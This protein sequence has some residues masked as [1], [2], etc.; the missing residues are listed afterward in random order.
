[1]KITKFSIKKIAI[2]FLIL[3]IFYIN[4][5]A[6]DTIAEDAIVLDPMPEISASSYMLLDQNTGHILMEHNID[7]MI[8]PASV[9]KIL[10]A[11]LVIENCDPDE[12]VTITKDAFWNI[13]Y[14]SSSAGLVEGEIMS[15]NDMLYCMML[16]SANEAS[17][18]LAIHIAGSVENFVAMMNLKAIQLGAYNSNFQNPNGLHDDNHY[19]TARDMSIVT[20]YALKNE[21][22]SQIVETAQ[23][24]ISATNKNSEKIVYTTNTLILRKSDPRYYQ[25]ANGIKTGFT[26]PAGNCLVSQAE[27]NNMQLI[28]LLFNCEKSS[29]GENMTSYRTVEMFEWGFSNHINKVLVEQ[30]KPVE[31][32]AVRLS[33]KSDYV[34]VKTAND[35]VGLVPK[36]YD[37]NKLEYLYSLPSTISAPI[38]VDQKI[39]TLKVMYD[40]LYYGSIDLLAVN[41]VEL[42]QVL[43]YVDL[44]EQF[45]ASDTFITILISL[46]LILISYVVFSKIQNNLKSKKR[47]Y[48]RRRST[49]YK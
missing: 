21:Y 32:V 37:E 19:T 31:T 2:L 18:A 39:G 13:T 40:G 27:K 33:S 10:T 15:V 46:I 34:S 30:L 16:A 24:S 5:L 43:Y 28:S 3:N 9:T 17:N 36:D 23:K 22:F 7:E 8:Y 29:S 38:F 1:M 47:K 25:Y 35:V 4:V 6:N 45:F 26:T 44:L 12:M 20:K 14:G 41:D 11:I 49:R 42:S 48:K